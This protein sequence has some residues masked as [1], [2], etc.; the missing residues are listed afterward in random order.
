[1]T[2]DRQV[3]TAFAFPGVGVRPSGCEAKFYRRHESMVR[4][5]LDEASHAAKTDLA[6]SLLRDQIEGLEEGTR[7]YFTYAFSAGVCAVLQDRGFVP[8][9][10]AGYSFGIYAAMYASGAISFTTGL[11]ILEE[12][13]RLMKD[14]C[15]GNPSGMGFVVGLNR[16]DISRVLDK[17]SYS[18][19]CLVNSNSDM[20]N[21]FAGKKKALEGFLAEAQAHGAL[22][23]EC[24]SVAIP[25]HHPRILSEVTPKFRAF[26]QTFE[27]ERPQCP[28]V[29]SI[30]QTLLV[31]V[32]ALIDFTA[33]N[34]STPNN[35]QG[36]VRALNSGSV[37][38]MIECGPGISLTQNGRFLP[39]AIKYVNIKNMLRSLGI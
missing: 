29:S 34:L 30:E 12:A 7:Q 14:A 4:P 19:L 38:R 15:N 2:A 31:D 35:W 36:V 9:F 27:W 22:A 17:K 8:E 28:V 10:T 21:I 11:S 37:E 16:A 5:F 3:R 32:D 39:Y 23:A 6:F 25:Y 33:R 20:C 1:M 24:L 18:S 13:Y 26:L